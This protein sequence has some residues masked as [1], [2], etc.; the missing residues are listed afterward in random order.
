MQIRLNKLVLEKL[1]FENLNIVKTCIIR[2]K[3][4][5]SYRLA[6]LVA[7]TW[8]RIRVVRCVPS[9]ILLLALLWYYDVIALI[10]WYY[11]TVTHGYSHNISSQTLNNDDSYNSQWGLCSC[12]PTVITNTHQQWLQE[13]REA[14]ITAVITWVQKPTV[15]SLHITS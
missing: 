15:L 14:A 2:N 12:S 5:S 8:P 13:C 11:N 6:A 3:S 4:W 10:L 7:C 9:L 1:S